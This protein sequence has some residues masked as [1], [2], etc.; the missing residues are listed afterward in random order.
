MPK[1]SCLIILILALFTGAPA[2]AQDA[3]DRPSDIVIDGVLNGAAGA[4]T[5]DIPFDV[6]A[7]T[8]SV[9]VRFVF[10]RQAGASVWL[11]LYDPDHFRGW[12]GGVKRDF[13]VAESF[14]TPSFNPGPMPS[15]RW[16]IAVTVPQ[17]RADARVP[18]QV[19]IDLGQQ[20]DPAMDAYSSVPVA[21]TPGWYRGDLHAHTGHSDAACRSLGGRS[22]PCPLFLTLQQAV[23]RQL[24]FIS[25]TD[26][27]VTSHFAPMGELAAYFDTLLLLPGREITTTLGHANLIGSM[28]PLETDLGR[29]G[30]ET[31]NVLLAAAHATGGFLSINHPAL[32][33]G[34][35]CVGCGWTAPETDFSLLDG[36]EAVG[37]GTIAELP[38][39]PEAGAAFHLSYWQDLL[40][41][42]YR[43]TGIAGSDNHDAVQH[44][45]ADPPIGPQSPVGRPTTV[46][47]AQELSQAGILAGLRAGRV[48]IDLGDGPGRLLDLSVRS[49]TQSA[50]MGQTL[51]RDPAS[52]TL[53]F[54]A[55]L[56]I[57]G[58]PEGAVTLLIGGQ[59]SPAPVALADTE[60]QQTIAITGEANPAARWIRA[61][62]RDRQGHLILVGNP[63]YLS[64]TSQDPAP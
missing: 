48:F 52:A 64:P 1:L 14:A 13:T 6:P 7:G 42:G 46:V 29:A 63:V 55:T 49:G 17:I 22:T 32:P 23:G 39:G 37:G 61:D 62:V 19:R 43:L 53:V 27:N 38:A 33:S 30:A 9:R 4:T 10:D 16:R 50:L 25:V 31:A 11:G 36:I 3:V 34:P 5:F 12:G 45:E 20:T 24:D 26:H 51:T 58:I 35:D 18:Y 47:H 59:S 15:G 8:R 21:A 57:R 60:A 41:R 54:E 56:T 40:S 2:W 44:L 28:D